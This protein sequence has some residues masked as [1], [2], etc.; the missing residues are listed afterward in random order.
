MKDRLKEIR[1]EIYEKACQIKQLKKDIKNLHME[2]DEI[3]GTK[4]LIK[5]R[6]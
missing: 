3:Q 6:K 5:K 1:H 4:K 2:V